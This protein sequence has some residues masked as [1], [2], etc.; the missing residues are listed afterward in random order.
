[1]IRSFGLSCYCVLTVM[2]VLL[3][4]LMVRRRYM[5]EAIQT[6]NP[7]DREQGT[8]KIDSALRFVYET[9]NSSIVQAIQYIIHPQPFPQAPAS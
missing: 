3:V 1:M 8:Q 7:G 9:S 5:N 2:V 4:L 6:H